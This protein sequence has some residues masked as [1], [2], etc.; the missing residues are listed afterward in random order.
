MR[1]VLAGGERIGFECLKILIDEK[2]D[3][4]AVLVDKNTKIENERVKSL[5]KKSGIKIHEISDINDSVF[6]DEMRKISPDIIFNTAFLHIYKSEVLSLPTKGCINFHPGPLP[7]YGGSNGWIWALING[8]KDYG[9]T[10]HYMKEKIDTGELVG[11]KNFPIEDEDTGMTLLSK[12]YTNGLELFMD[13]LKKLSDG[14]LISYPQDLNLRTY[15][16][17]KVPNGGV[18]DAAWS[19]RKIVNFVRALDFSPFPNPLSPPMIEFEDTKIIVKKASVLEDEPPINRCRGEVVEITREGVVM[20]ADD[21][22]VKMILLDSSIP[23][24]DSSDV[25]AAKGIGEGAILGRANG[26]S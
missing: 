3:V 19:S 21:G 23:T 1:V 2:V 10:F 12:C 13:I 6:L 7:R 18:I 17:N 26:D 14:S 8:E 22:L 4:A 11:I 9:V 5:A 15:Y 20:K 16:Y 24:A 25:C